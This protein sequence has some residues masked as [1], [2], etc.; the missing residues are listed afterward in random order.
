M[1]LN[2][3]LSVTF[4]LLMVFLGFGRAAEASEGVHHMPYLKVCA[5][6]LLFILTNTYY[7]FFVKKP[8]AR[9][10]WSFVTVFCIPVFEMKFTGIIALCGLSAYLTAILRVFY[11]KKKGLWLCIIFGL[12]VAFLAPELIFFLLLIN[13]FLFIRSRE[14]AY[15]VMAGWF[16]PFLLSRARAVELGYSWIPQ[17]VSTLMDS[18]SSAMPIQEQAS[19]FLF[20][21]TEFMQDPVFFLIFLGVALSPFVSNVDDVHWHRYFRIALLFSFPVYFGL[22]GLTGI[23]VDSAFFYPGFLF[24][25]SRYYP[26]YKSEL[27]PQAC[28]STRL[29]VLIL[30]SYLAFPLY[31]RGIHCWF[32]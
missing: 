25:V 9:V 24:L 11:L 23:P 30:L 5:I 3:A 8:V 13:G 18:Y 32:Q 12:P 17:S 2:R 16:L 20:Q 1:R 19:L 6:I 29:G 21:S 15:F 22:F 7:S 4:I 28:C 27:F 31:Q 10:I 26:L 14:S